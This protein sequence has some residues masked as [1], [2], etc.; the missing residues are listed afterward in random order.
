[1]F[2]G[3][4]PGLQRIWSDNVRLCASVRQTRDR[5]FLWRYP[6]REPREE[7]RQ[8]P[9][10]TIIDLVWRSAC[11]RKPWCRPCC[12]PTVKHVDVRVAHGLQERRS[13]DAARAA[14]THRHNGGILDAD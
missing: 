9:W 10:L 7:P 11:E 3:G 6:G 14:V 8:P 12:C 1:M 5:Q 2:T 13:E 4:K